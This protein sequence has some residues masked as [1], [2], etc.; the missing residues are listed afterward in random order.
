MAGSEA[1]GRCVLVWMALAGGC[2]SD[3]GS[4]AEDRVAALIG[5]C[6]PRELVVATP[7]P[8]HRIEIGAREVTERERSCLAAAGTSCARAI[9]CMHLSL[10]RGPC[11]RGC[12]GTTV[13][14]CATPIAP[15]TEL[16]QVTED[17]GAFGEVCADTPD[18]HRCVTG[19]CERFRCDGPMRAVHCSLGVEVTEACTPGTTCSEALQRCTGTLCTANT[20]DGDVASLCDVPAGVVRSTVDCAAYGARC[21][22]GECV[23]EEDECMPLD[24]PVCDG[25]QVR[26]CRFAGTVAHI[27]CVSLGF[28]PCDQGRCTAP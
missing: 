15:E 28:G 14:S 11:A 16:L 7:L 27:D 5:A 20:C 21:V 3:S 24:A 23:P 1:L 4:S 9:A 25:T 18:D 2:A 8:E 22:A 26:W 13:T 12:D 17:C 19:T 10:A 6:F